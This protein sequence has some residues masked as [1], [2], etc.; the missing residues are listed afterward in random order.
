VKHIILETNDTANAKLEIPP[1]L[2][3]AKEVTGDENYTGYKMAKTA[4]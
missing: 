1:F 3:I 4:S 2:Q